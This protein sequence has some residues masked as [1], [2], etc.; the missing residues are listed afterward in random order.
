MSRG[1]N[2]LGQLV[3]ETVRT[4][5]SLYYPNIVVSGRERVP[6]SGPV[7]FVANHAN[8][9]MDPVIVGIA[10]RRPIHFLAKAPLFDTPVLGPAMKALGMLPAY[11][12]VD[13][14]A[15]VAKNA[16]T[17]AAAAACL[18]SG[19]AVGIFPEGKSHDALKVDQVKTGA[20]RMA[21]QAVAQGAKG[22]KIVPL[23]LNY[24]RKE[25]FRSSVWVQVGEPIDVG[26][27]LAA[28]NTPPTPLTRPSDTLS[29]HPMRGE[30]RGEGCSGPTQDPS[31]PK[32][33]RHAMRELTHEIDR[34]LKAVVIH[35]EHV[36]WEP[37]LRDLEVLLPSGEERAVEAV[38]ALRQR[39]RLADAINHFMEHDRRR[40]LRVAV[41]IKR[42][43]ND[44]ASSGLDVRSLP[45][46]FRRMPLFVRLLSR[47]LGLIL[48]TPPTLLGMLH[49][50]LPFAIVRA[51]AARFEAGGRTTRSLMRL[52]FGLPVYGAWYAVV[53]WGMAEYFRPGVATAWALCMIPAGTFALAYSR[54]LRTVAVDWWH[55]MRSFSLGPKVMEWRDQQRAIGTMLG[56][57]ERAYAGQRPE[58]PDLSTRRVWHRRACFA[59]TVAILGLLALLVAAWIRVTTRPDVLPELQ[60]TGPSLAGITYDTLNQMLADDEAALDELLSSLHKLEADA[61]RVKAE[62]DGGRRS[63]YRQEDDDAI[64]QLLLRYLACRTELLRLV[65]Q[66]QHYDSTRFERP[67]LRAF[68]LAFTSGV[69]LFDASGRFVSLFEGSP[70]AIR[71]LNE[72]EPRWGIP[73]DLYD[74]VRHNLTRARNR[75]LLDRAWA[76]YG[77]L[78]DTFA[79]HALREVAPW[80]R[81]HQALD[82]MVA[83]LPVIAPEAEA[84][85]T[86][87]L[88]EARDMGKAAVYWGQSVV[89]TWVGDTRVREP[90]RGEALIQPRQLEEVRRQLQ[91]GDIL[92]ERQNWFL[93][94]AF[95]PGYWAHAALYVGSPED[96]QRLGLANDP[97]VAAH[98]NV[99]ATPDEKGHVRVVLEAVPRGVRMNTLEHCLGIADSAA[100]LRPKVSSAALHEAIAEA[101][102]HLNKPY[103][104]EFDFFSA[105]KLVCTELV[106]RCYDGAVKLDLVNVMGRQTLPPTELVRTY[107]TGKQSGQAPFDFVCFL[108]GIEAEGVAR[109]CDEEAF[110]GTVNRPSLTWL[111]GR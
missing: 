87:V 28:R 26:E 15:Q 80:V 66:Y 43:R 86:A 94:R 89:S 8:S 73:P 45:V 71:K 81:F 85:P 56:D 97:R 33:D 78:G 12:G 83:R 10:S 7:L 46:R 34:R 92:I 72:P 14:R 96:L 38:G 109:F 99:F 49:H 62:F 4:V 95:M 98:W 20:A 30:G 40:A 25:Q 84:T 16:E 104:F 6:A 13:S 101:F 102:S 69:A 50:V 111:Q 68:L 21:L 36:E 76:E 106:Y 105:D 93:S 107:V 41:A 77:M 22:L 59:A 47:T 90:R 1:L 39:K 32:E 70:D 64:R 3:R 67:R 9:L 58:E 65:W 44:L 52:G 110:S 63:F 35:L 24:E 75:D 48:G 88:K 60:G 5:V 91:P 57:L 27:W 17:L 53:W 23:G 29:P 55:E 42:H 11:R 2:I 79:T 100:V 108:D 51:L 18:A 103:D 19:E 37:F 74:T 31:Q 61:L 82:E 54:T